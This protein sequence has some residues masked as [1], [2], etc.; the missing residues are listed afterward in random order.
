[1]DVEKIVKENQ[2]YLN[3]FEKWLKEKKLSIKTIREHLSNADL[4]LNDYLAYRNEETLQEGCIEVDDFISDFFIH[5]CMWSSVYS[6]K[7]TV[8]SIKKFY[9]CMLEYG[10]IESESYQILCDIIKENMD[11]W[12]EEMEEYDAFC[13]ED[14]EF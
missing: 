9:S 14:W 4:Y 11:V 3:A 12:I 8:A 5:K 13:F 1:M 2:K 7:T 10:Y 6:I